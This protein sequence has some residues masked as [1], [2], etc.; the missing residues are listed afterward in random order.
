MLVELRKWLLAAIAVSVVFLGGCASTHEPSPTVTVTAPTPAPVDSNQA[1]Y[2]A[3]TSLGLTLNET[4][5]PYLVEL[6]VL[7][8]DT[9]RDGAS[10]TEIALAVGSGTSD[11]QMT[12][13][14]IYAAV[15]VECPVYSEAMYE[16][17][18]NQV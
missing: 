1:L 14:I 16:W 5:K 7:V 8:C 2:D 12:A 17:S 13:G 11:A 9:L 10:F 18:G 4:Q 6:S 15:V 3:Y